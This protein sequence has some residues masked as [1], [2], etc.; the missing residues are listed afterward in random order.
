MCKSKIHRARVTKTALRYKGSIGID[1]GLL[2]AADIYP[3]EVVQV[4]NFQNGTRFETYVIK[5][6]ENSGEIVLYGPAA[7]MGEV[8]DS[9]VI[10]SKALMESEEARLLKA[11]FVYVDEKNRILKK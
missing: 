8:G 9:V 11:K 5:E 10:I 2:R 4:V 1:A 7:R 6:K 3:N